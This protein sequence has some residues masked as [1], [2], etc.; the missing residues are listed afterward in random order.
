MANKVDVGYDFGRGFLLRSR[1]PLNVTPIVQDG[2]LVGGRGSGPAINSA[3][4]PPPP[5][6]GY[7]YDPSGGLT[8]EVLTVFQ[9]LDFKAKATPWEMKWSSLCTS[10]GSF[11]PIVIET[12]FL[13]K[14]G[15]GTVAGHRGQVGSDSLVQYG[16][17]TYDKSSGR[18]GGNGILW[19]VDPSD[20]IPPDKCPY[21]VPQMSYDVVTT[22]DGRVLQILGAVDQEALQDANW[23]INYV[24]A[25]LIAPVLVKLAAEGAARLCTAIM[26]QVEARAART[27][28]AGLTNDLAEEASELNFEVLSEGAPI[29]GTS[30]PES[31]RLRVGER[32]FD[33]SRN[34]AKIDK[35]TGQPIGPATKHLAEEAKGGPWND[36]RVKKGAVIPETNEANVWLRMSQVDFPMSSLASGLQHAERRILTGAPLVSIEGSPGVYKVAVEGWEFNIDTTVDPWR[37]Y[38]LQII[39]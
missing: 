23:I 14:F 34:A 39:D 12:T 17:P 15:M 24:I 5:I 22:M 37:V 27:L 13:R 7:R 1:Q 16:S 29:P 4:A 28:M 9:N 35:A 31:L 25:P 20:P 26:E 11:K 38:H 18:V 10:R 2:H 33:I 19:V 21:G 3:A 32:E 8:P 36:L 30:V 6:T